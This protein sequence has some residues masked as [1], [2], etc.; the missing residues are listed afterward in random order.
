MQVPKPVGAPNNLLPTCYFCVF[1]IRENY[2]LFQVHDLYIRRKHTEL[3][4]EGYLEFYK[5]SSICAKL[6]FHI[7][8]ICKYLIN[9]FVM[10]SLMRVPVSLSVLYII[11]LKIKTW[12]PALSVSL[13]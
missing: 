9:L 4:I 5:K 2:T 6:P 7:A 12:I 10:K 1:R 3:R 8:T 13:T 11:A